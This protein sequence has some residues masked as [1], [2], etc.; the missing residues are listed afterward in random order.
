MLDIV[1][2]RACVRPDNTFTIKI[3]GANLC[4]KPEPERQKKKNNSI[5]KKNRHLPPIPSHISL[6]AIRISLRT[7]YTT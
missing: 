7:N 5:K 4:R 3:T 2:V 6:L 1:I